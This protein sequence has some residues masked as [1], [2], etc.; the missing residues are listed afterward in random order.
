MNNREFIFDSIDLN[1][2]KTYFLEASAGTGKT[3]AIS[4]IFTRLVIEDFKP[5][6]ILVVTFTNAAA[7]ELKGRILRFLNE[8]KD[9]LSFESQHND[10]QEQSNLQRLTTINKD[11]EFLCYLTKLKY[12][13][14]ICKKAITN[15][16]NSIFLFDRIPVT[17]IHSFIIKQISS[18]SILLDLPLDFNI[19]INCD[20]I[21]KKLIHRFIIKNSFQFHLIRGEENENR[22]IDEN[23]GDI[24]IKNGNR[25]SGDSLLNF[26]EVI[27]NLNKIPAFLDNRRTANIVYHDD[28]LYDMLYKFVKFY[29]NE[30]LDFKK[31]SNI[32]NFNDTI[33]IFDKLLSNK[34]VLDEFRDMFDVLLIDEFQDTDEIQTSI[35]EKIFDGKLSFYIGD[36][37]QAI[38]NF[39]GGNVQ[40]YLKMKENIAKKN[41]ENILTLNKTFRFNRDI[42][43]FINFFS[44]TY[45][46]N[47]D[48]NIGTVDS[49]YKIGY[50]DVKCARSEENTFSN[51][52]GQKVKLFMLNRDN[53]LI[54]KKKIFAYKIIDR[55]K[56]LVIKD[57]KSDSEN[58]RIDYKDIVILCKNK[59]DAN[60]Y[61]NFL[62]TCGIPA[63]L[64]IDKSIFNTDEALFLYY[65]LDAIINKSDIE[66]IKIAI[67]TPVFDINL[68][69]GDE[70][71]DKVISQYLT[72]FED[73][74]ISWK[75]YGI[76]YVFNEI[77]IKRFINSKDEDNFNLRICMN[78][79]SYERRMTNI[80][81]IFELLSIY[82]TSTN[83]AE[84]K[85]VEF[86]G[87]LI[88][89]DEDEV[90]FEEGFTSMRLESEENTVLISTIHSAKGL[91]YK[92]V[93]YPDI[94][95][96]TMNKYPMAFY[97]K[98]DGKIQELIL[99][100][101]IEKN[102]KL[103]IN[104]RDNV[105]STVQI[106]PADKDSEM[107][108]KNDEKK[109][110]ISTLIKKTQ[111]LELNNL[112]YVALTRA[113][114]F[115]NIF[116]E[117]IK[118]GKSIGKEVVANDNS[119][120]TNRD[121]QS[122]INQKEPE[123][124]E[125][126]T[127]DENITRLKERFGNDIF[128]EFSSSQF[129]CNEIIINESLDKNDKQSKIDSMKTKLLLEDI[130]TLDKRTDVRNK[131]LSY[132]FI[133]NYA[134]KMIIDIKPIQAESMEER[135][136][137][138]IENQKINRGYDE[139]EQ[140]FS[141]ALAGI[142]IHSIL[143]NLNKNQKE[144]WKNSENNLE[145]LEQLCK[146]NISV[147]FE[148]SDRVNLYAKDSTTLICNTLNAIL[149]GTNIKISDIN[150][151]Q[152]EVEFIIP[153]KSN[154]YIKLSR[155][156]C[157]ENCVLSGEGEGLEN[158]SYKD[159]S[160]KDISN[161]DIYRK[162]LENNFKGFFQG[163]I[164]L[165]F[166]HDKKIY[167]I[168]WKTNRLDFVEEKNQ[169]YA[170]L[171]NELTGS[172]EDLSRDKIFEDKK[173]EDSNILSSIKQT[174][175]KSYYDIQ[176]NLYSA[177]IYK[178]LQSYNLLDKYQLGG[179][180]YCFVRY[181]AKNTT[182]AIYYK[183][184]DENYKRYLQDVSS[185]I[186]I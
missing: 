165:M 75:K 167:I 132:T 47:E 103:S 1:L 159:I 71:F 42:T 74:L 161:K 171:L 32:L 85:V 106:I 10:S 116:C 109:M 123:F 46:F 98:I 20:E 81:Q 151:S 51:I 112:R 33:E 143:E 156:L 23:D 148:N 15:L 26:E 11:K 152:S 62:S 76:M 137:E 131:L 134:K 115:L 21:Y 119:L 59:N 45:L 12:T 150:L 4:K 18:Y 126:L 145:E 158:E 142:V 149:P 70:S 129:L 58:E 105:F 83:C 92:V 2:N 86:L 5:E 87:D 114:E 41:S 166:I 182:R 133:G 61:R 102:D 53:E 31:Q 176:Y 153:S 169:D 140:S 127:S 40:N 82:E 48:S 175:K 14:L 17:T 183:E 125:L 56:E 128:D 144:I 162:D 110:N 90:E 43:D 30:S 3:H 16:E 108:S 94:Q 146:N 57:I 88:F 72:F 95:V 64:K 29:R 8:T 68:I 135:V 7:D 73:L 79:D 160:D 6:K 107:Q 66:K 141:G 37:K 181:M 39:R 9:Y 136:L 120:K 19:S 60:Y 124:K 100:K 101:T 104:L 185:K 25:K 93:F 69:N 97:H 44:K 168:D 111:N 49:L 24:K 99:L 52:D 178:Y 113:K 139:K 28:Y 36:P 174:I 163:F 91:E 80:R 155:I 177:A 96:G 164:D 77:F 67:L 186:F 122:K 89:N 65:I 173:D 22:T 38:Y 147:H 55:I 34:K 117:K 172:H 84:V 27:K 154:D 184:I 78:T 13:P 130:L 54:D 118:I 35:F 121:I 50:Q 138:F 63:A 179:I 180:Y 157:D 170:D